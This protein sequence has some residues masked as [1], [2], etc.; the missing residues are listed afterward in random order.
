MLDWQT[1]SGRLYSQALAFGGEAGR[2]GS[3]GMMDWSSPCGLSRGWSQGSQ[4]SNVVS[5]QLEA[6]WASKTWPWESHSV[7]SDSLCSRSRGT[8]V[9]PV[10]SGRMSENLQPFL[11]NHNAKLIDRIQGDLPILHSQ[12]LLRPFPFSIFSVTSLAWILSLSSVPLDD[13]LSWSLAPGFS[14]LHLILLDVN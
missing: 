14:P 1:G 9:G 4:T 12:Y 2:L 6:T 3:A 11:K 8:D 10:S 5:G 13:A 7:S